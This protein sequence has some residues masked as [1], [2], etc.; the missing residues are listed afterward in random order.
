MM[1]PW[2]YSAFAVTVADARDIAPGWRRL[3]LAAPELRD[4]APWGL[5]QRIKLVLPLPDG[6]LAD[7][8]LM[9]QPTPHPSDWYAR[10]KALP[11]TE[12]NVLRTYTPSAIRPEQ[13]EIDVDVLLH[14]PPGPAS[15]WAAQATPGE[16][17]WIT[18]PDR[19]NG[20]TGYGLHWQPVAGATRWLLVGDE[21]A[22]PAIA[23]ILR[24]LPEGGRADVLLEAAD[25]RDDIVSPGA[26][27]GA[28][29]RLVL[30]GAVA[31][32]ALEA[33]VRDTPVDDA[34]YVWLAGEAGAVTRI[35]RHLTAERGVPKDR[36]SFLGYWKLGG[37]LVG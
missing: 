23:N 5:D 21:T 12:R 32:D 1:R 24:T 3:T 4:F 18:G 10:W 22:F 27:D 33:A 37:P 2:E 34:E 14:E 19:R 20:W 7:F 11:E 26:P 35:R 36:V 15:A 8:G 9:T 28:H 13:G 6:G 25:V 31:G 17:L 30:R 29:V 16:R